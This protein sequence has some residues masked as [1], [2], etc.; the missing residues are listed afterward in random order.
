MMYQGGSG[1]GHDEVEAMFE[2]L[3]NYDAISD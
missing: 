1:G 3:N 2:Q